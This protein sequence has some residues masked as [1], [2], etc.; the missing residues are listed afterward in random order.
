M[1]T[2]LGFTCSLPPLRLTGCMNDNLTRD[3]L[4][5]ID[6]SGSMSLSWNQLMLCI[7]LYD[8]TPS[9]ET[10]T[11]LTGGHEQHPVM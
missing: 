8:V 4:L 2:A 5:D 3:S 6:V 9:S 10:N 1:E 11:R 7:V